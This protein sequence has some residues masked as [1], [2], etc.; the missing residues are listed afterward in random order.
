MKATG[1]VVM[2]LIILTDRN[3][4]EAIKR[5]ISR[6]A[7]ILMPLSVLLIEFYPTVGRAYNF[8]D[9]AFTNTGVTTNKNMLGV[10]CLVAGL[11]CFWLFVKVLLEKRRRARNLLAMGATLATIL[12]LFVLANSVTSLFCFMMGA[13][14][15]VLVNLPGTH[16]TSNIHV[17]VAG[18]LS[19]AA[20]IFVFPE[21]FTSIIHLFGRTTTL[22]GRTDLWKVL[23]SMDTHPWLGAG[24]ESFW[25]GN[26]DGFPLEHFPVAAQ[27]GP[28]RLSGSLPEP[29][30]GRRDSAAGLAG[31]GLPAPGVR[32]PEGPGG[33]Q[34]EA[35]V[36]CR[37]DGLQLCG[38]RVPD[39]RSHV[40][41]SPAGDY[42]GARHGHPQEVE[43][44]LDA[45][46]E[47]VPVEL[48]SD[49]DVVYERVR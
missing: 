47:F 6:V 22:T 9:G 20:L 4:L 35:G 18:M 30:M 29:G 39:A 31:Y 36:L 2:V 34:P 1:D 14:L 25:L 33:R 41:F 44:P 15:I 12:L 32:L 24:F 46:Q 48:L 42:C 23:L 45:S 38:G 8:E 49:D 28:Q 5:V 43:L 10:L 3:R 27:R 16:R 21:I 17:V 40:D 37:R 13:T 7:F 19:V 11:G 26:S